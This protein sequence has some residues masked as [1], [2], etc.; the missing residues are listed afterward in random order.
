MKKFSGNNTLNYTMHFYIIDNDSSFHNKLNYSLNH[1]SNYHISIFKSKE[2]FLN[3]YS[4]KKF[5]KGHDKIHIII[6]DAHQ[7]DPEKDLK[8]LK[9]IKRK[10]KNTEF[11]ILT[12][13][14]SNKISSFAL[15]VGVYE[16]IQKNDNIFYRLE[17][18]AKSINSL[19]NFLRKKKSLR[20][21]IYAL[22]IFVALS[23]SFFYFLF[24]IQG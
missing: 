24:L 8:L 5:I 3:Q 12:D 19:Y 14:V 1:N 10:N 23:G 15:D 11:I 18:A 9:N 4:E 22:I 13:D 6:I 21:T 7:L 20:L 17:N 16:I 2:E